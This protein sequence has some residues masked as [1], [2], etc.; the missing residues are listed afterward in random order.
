[1]L[2]VRFL[3]ICG[4]IC[5]YAMKWFSVAHRVLYHKSHHARSDIAKLIAGLI[6]LPVFQ[7][8]HLFFKFAYLLN[9]RR[10]AL[11]GGE[12]LF[13]EISDGRISFDSIVRIS[14]RLRYIEH[15]LECADT[16]KYLSDHA[17]SSSAEMPAPF[18]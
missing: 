1:V 14:N 16:S 15:S 11:L 2:Q 17:V 10:I 7:A 12:D 4:A 18:V 5:A 8:S 3:A 13:P 9:R 6:S